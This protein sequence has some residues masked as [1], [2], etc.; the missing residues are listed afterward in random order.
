MMKN[1]VVA[2]VTGALI[3][4]LALVSPLFAQGPIDE[5]ILDRTPWE[6]TG[7]Q[8]EYCDPV[9]RICQYATLVDNEDNGGTGVPDNDMGIDGG[10][11]WYTTCSADA[12]HPIEF[13]IHVS[14]ITYQVDAWLILLA[15]PGTDLG[16]IQKVTFNGAEVTEHRSAVS[17]PSGL[18]VWLGHLDP[19]QVLVGDN[20][21]QVYLR[22]GACI[23]VMES[24]LFMADQMLWAEEFVPEP[25]TLALLGS[26]LV[27][28]AGYAGLRL[29]RRR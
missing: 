14:S 9:E 29:R 13:N 20:L 12:K 23:S 19:S 2:A 24:V 26:G 5:S 3:M 17:S 25:G 1:K 8:A 18:A 21:V 11:G 16:G 15:P 7:S 10:G 27:G 22:S 4:T 28:L 6:A